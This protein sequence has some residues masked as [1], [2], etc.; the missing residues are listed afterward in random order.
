MRQLSP[1]D[2]AS[3]LVRARRDHVAWQPGD[4]AAISI[5]EAYA[6]HDLVTAELGLAIGAWKTS[7]LDDPKAP[8]AGQIYARDIYGTGAEIPASE[9]FMIGIEGEIAFRFGQDFP[10]SKAP[11]GRADIIAG[12]SEMLPL[13]EVV[14]S[15]MVDGMGQDASLKMADNQSN[16]AIVI[17]APVTTGWQTI[18]ATTQPVTL[19][20]NGAKVYGDVSNSPVADVFALMAGTVNVCAARGHPI[21]AGQII[22]T[23]SCTGVL[24]FEP[25]SQVVMDM[26]AVGRVEVSFPVA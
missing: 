12:I 18:D 14:D 22:T 4:T 25:G 11:Y 7:P 20:V 2:I 8:F 9:L 23:G 17:G 24:F 16:A 15:R 21:A 13:I 19:H 6:V 26:P 10:A 5:A 3:H 1:A